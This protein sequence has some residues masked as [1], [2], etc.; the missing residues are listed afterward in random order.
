M[1]ISSFGG[2]MSV[3]KNELLPNLPKATDVETYLSNMN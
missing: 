1:E 2:Q 3:L